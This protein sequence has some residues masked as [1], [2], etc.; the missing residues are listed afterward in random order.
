MLPQCLCGFYL[1]NNCDKN[2]NLSNASSSFKLGV[3]KL[4]NVNPS[5]MVDSML[6]AE[7]NGLINVDH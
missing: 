1:L 6:C 2:L 4:G 3:H 7:D 5:G